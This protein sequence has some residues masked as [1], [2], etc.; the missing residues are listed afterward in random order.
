MLCNITYVPKF[1][2]VAKQDIDAFRSFLLRH[3][4]IAIITGA[5]ISTESGIPDYRSEGV[6]LYARSNHKPIQ[7]QEFLK[8]EYARQ[9]YWARNFTGWPRF[10]QIQPNSVHYSLKNLEMLGK[11]S[12]IITQNVDN[13]HYKAGSKNVLELH[14]TA[15][16]VMCLSCKDYFSRHDFQNILS[17]TN[18]NTLTP[19]AVIRPDGDVEITDDFVKDFKVPGCHKCGGILKPDVIFFGDNVPKQQV[20]SVKK[21][22]TSSN[23]LLVLGTSLSTFSAYRIIL[24]A[25][26]ENKEIFVINIGPTRADGEI[27]F[28]IST[29]CGDI[30]PKVT[31]DLIKL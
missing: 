18:P 9:R 16:R 2:P 11:A 20:E 29:K 15:H 13:L 10:S 5:G 22:I 4:K 30:I 19:T 24:Q 21:E 31:N 25:K 3:E 14:G 12:T 26:E 6:G 7:Y 1:N 23:A 28:K 27:N 8:S 17:K